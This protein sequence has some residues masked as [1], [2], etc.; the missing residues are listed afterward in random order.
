MN[1]LQ[2]LLQRGRLYIM[3]H[4]LQRRGDTGWSAN[5]KIKATIFYRCN[6]SLLQSYSFLL[7]LNIV[8]I[9]L[10]TIQQWPQLE[11]WDHNVIHTNKLKATKNIC[12]DTFSIFLKREAWIRS[13]HML[14]YWNQAQNTWLELWPTRNVSCFTSMAGKVM[15]TLTNC[16]PCHHK[17][18]RLSRCK[19]T[20]DDK[21]STCV[22]TYGNFI[23]YFWFCLIMS[24]GKDGQRR[25]SL[26]ETTYLNG[27]H[28]IYLFFRRS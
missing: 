13:P 21:E 19:V 9:Q 20:V 11:K 27:L 22:V 2:L 16:V 26:N 28:S 24:G 8:T 3:I 25:L 10:L 4:S 5:C 1:C 15:H 12:R 6:R 17:L 18:F 7:T 23:F 14:S